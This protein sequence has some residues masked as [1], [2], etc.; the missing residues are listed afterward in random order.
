MAVPVQSA[1]VSLHFVRRPSPAAGL[2]A[3]RLDRVGTGGEFGG[4]DRAEE[5]RAVTA[6]EIPL[7]FLPS[8]KTRRTAGHR[9]EDLDRY[10]VADSAS[11]KGGLV[12]T[13]KFA[14]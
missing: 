8:G 3:E 5:R 14:G 10:V 11:R 1:E 6:V 2:L 4:S 9:Y 12:A 7:R 13:A